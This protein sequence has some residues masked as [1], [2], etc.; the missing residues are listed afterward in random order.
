M[1]IAGNYGAFNY[2]LAGAIP[3]ILDFPIESIVTVI[4]SPDSN[5]CLR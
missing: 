1:I 3:E 5:L 4:P 2:R